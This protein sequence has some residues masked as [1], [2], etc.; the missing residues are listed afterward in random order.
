VFN[1]RVRDNLLGSSIALNVGRAIA[2]ERINK[3]NKTNGSYTMKTKTT[4]FGSIA[5][6]ILAVLFCFFV[7]AISAQA[8]TNVTVDNV[9]AEAGTTIN[10]GTDG[11]QT[12]GIWGLVLKPSQL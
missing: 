5:A 12:K 1:G 9:Y 3:N 7:T 4:H 2:L 10:F 6:K 8:L 11:C